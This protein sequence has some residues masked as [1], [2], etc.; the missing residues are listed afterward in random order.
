[1]IYSRFVLYI[2]I[3]KQQDYREVLVFHGNKRK[4]RRKNINDRR[5]M[6]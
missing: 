6:L 3:G 4:R 2:L 1:V 5:N